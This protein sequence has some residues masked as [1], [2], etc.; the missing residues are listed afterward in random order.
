[1]L[2]PLPYY[3]G[4]TVHTYWIVF[5][6]VKNWRTTFNFDMSEVSSSRWGHHFDHNSPG[7]FCAKVSFYYQNTH[8]QQSTY[9]EP[10]CISFYLY[11][12][13]WFISIIMN[14]S[15]NFN[16]FVCSYH[17]WWP[18]Q[19]SDL[20]W[21]QCWAVSIRSAIVQEWLGSLAVHEESCLQKCIKSIIN[22]NVTVSY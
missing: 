7:F 20:N 9:L 13:I 18:G 8:Q 11:L 1:M 3:S 5:D 21:I 17:K 15:M 4:T 12:V 2:V 10:F 6:L 14:F 16:Y 19:H 22:H